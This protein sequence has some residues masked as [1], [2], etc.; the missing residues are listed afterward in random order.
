MDLPLAP[1][2]DRHVALLV[3]SQGSQQAG[4][5][6]STAGAGAGALE[7]EN[8]TSAFTAWPP[9]YEIQHAP[10]PQPASLGRYTQK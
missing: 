8:N 7:A 9:L 1:F 4:T 3:A 2:S 5:L 6:S 10:P